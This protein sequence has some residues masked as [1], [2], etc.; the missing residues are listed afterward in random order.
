M[1]APTSEKKPRKVR[2]YHVRRLAAI[3]YMKSRVFKGQSNR[4]IA[5]DHGVSRNTVERTLTW[6][7]RAGIFVELED[8]LVADIAP[9]AL[10]TI[11]HALE[12]DKN[13]DVALEILKGLNIL[14]KNHPITAKEV[15]DQDDLASYI[16]AARVQAQLDADTTD[17]VLLNDAATGRDRDLIPGYSPELLQLGDG[18]PPAGPS[19]DAGDPERVPG[20]NHGP[21]EAATPVEG[22]NGGENR[23]SLPETNA[24]DAPVEG[25]SSESRPDGV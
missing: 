17:G 1:E 19:S 21:T 10:M 18:H 15:K 4:E 20:G 6:A 2:D 25:G 22:S 7:E 14:K 5:K 11:K 8:Q 23:V 3:E 13:A 24:P 12:H 9:V 16:T